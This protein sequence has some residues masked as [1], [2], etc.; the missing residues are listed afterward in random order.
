MM[1]NNYYF[2]DIKVRFVKGL[3]TTVGELSTYAQTLA[4]YVG[5]LRTHLNIIEN[6]VNETSYFSRKS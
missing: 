4:G 5:T 3:G 6:A 2:S 1:T